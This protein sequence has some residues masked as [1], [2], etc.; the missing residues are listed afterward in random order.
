M[1]APKH[2]PK[3][4]PEEL[5]AIKFRAEVRSSRARRRGVA[6]TLAPVACLK[7]EPLDDYPTEDVRDVPRKR[8]APAGVTRAGR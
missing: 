2:G 6:I 4:T 3:L 8:P 1:M 7:E 5:L